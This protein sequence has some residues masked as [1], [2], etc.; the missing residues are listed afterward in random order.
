MNCTQNPLIAPG[1]LLQK[2]KQSPKTQ[3]FIETTRSSICNILQGLDPRLLVVVGPCSI[4]DPKAALQY[5][6][7][8][9]EVIPQFSNELFIIMRMYFEKPRTT[10]GWKGL[11]SDPHLNGSYDINAGF[12]LARQLLLDINNLGVPA[13]TEFLDTITPQ[14]ISDLISWSA[15]G[16]RTSESQ[17]HRELASGLPMPVGFKNSTDGNIKIAIDAILATLNSHHYLS[18]NQNGNPAIFSTHGN[19]FTHIILRGSHSAPNYDKESIRLAEKMMKDANL[20]P[21]IMIDCSH[22]N[23]MKNYLNQ[24]KVV[25][26]ITQQLRANSQSIC[27]VMIESNLVAGNQ[28]LEKKQPL[29]YGQSIT[30]ECISWTQT[31]PLLRELAEAVRERISPFEKGG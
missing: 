6:K 14:Y 22:G 1:A 16:A 11:I 4:H 18:V 2:L 5:A 13:A 15:I 21:N 23:S 27:G 9:N 25:N 28:V 26:S 24:K 30:D 29:K 17:I 10:I 31:L 12:E 19:K 7:L 8:L 3:Q 20:R